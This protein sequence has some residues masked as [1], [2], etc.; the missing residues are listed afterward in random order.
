MSIWSKLFGSDE[1]VNGTVSLID[2]AF[3]TDEEKA[4]MKKELLR[5]Y[6]PFKIAQRYIAMTF[7][8]VYAFAWL[9]TFLASFF[10]DVKSQVEMLLNP[11]GLAGIV[12]AIVV[13]YFGGGTINSLKK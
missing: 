7:C 11:M 5:C 12:L 4:E 3:Y 10:T 2:N 1:V 13:F 6:E 9:V 8:P